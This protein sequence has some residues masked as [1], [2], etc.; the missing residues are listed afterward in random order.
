M[1]RR[2]S[3]GASGHE[4]SEYPFSPILQ[5]PALL[6]KLLRLNSKDRAQKSG[7]DNRQIPE[8]HHRFPFLRPS[9][10]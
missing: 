9:T 4:G 2:K 8:F 7:N 5:F 10:R 1:S 3:A 6:Q